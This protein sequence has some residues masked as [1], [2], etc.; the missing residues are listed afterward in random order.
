MLVKLKPERV[1]IGWLENNDM[2][3]LLKTLELRYPVLMSALT[4]SGLLVGIAAAIAW[5]GIVS[6]EIFDHFH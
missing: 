3:K 2:Q 5:F 1:P 4:T 6:Y